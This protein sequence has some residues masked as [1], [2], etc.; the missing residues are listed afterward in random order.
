MIG[1]APRA[2]VDDLRSGDV[3]PVSGAGVTLEL[4][5]DTDFLLGV[6]GFLSSTISKPEMLDLDVGRVSS[7]FLDTVFSYGLNA[8]FVSDGLLR[9]VDFSD[10]KAA[11]GVRESLLF[12][13]LFFDFSRGE[14]NGFD[15]GESAP[16]WLHV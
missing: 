3:F 15:E 9:E 10:F 8:S 16:I 5:G 2:G 11:G 1:L 13:A 4:F 14:I 7:D 12:E 6:S